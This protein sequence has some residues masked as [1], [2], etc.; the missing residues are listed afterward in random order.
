MS[1]PFRLSYQATADCPRRYAPLSVRLLHQ[2]VSSTPLMD[3]MMRLLPGPYFSEVAPAKG[4]HE[5]ASGEGGSSTSSAKGS[6]S[7][8]SGAGGMAAGSSTG[9]GAGSSITSISGGGASDTGEI[10]KRPPVTLVLFVGGCTYAEI[11]ALRWLGRNG[12]PKREYLIATT[13]ITNGDQLMEA[14]METLEN[15]LTFEGLGLGSAS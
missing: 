15:G 10:R 9:E 13:H 1:H 8:S 14:M 6:S 12:T 5:E 11:A 3:E 4:E 7:G 2:M